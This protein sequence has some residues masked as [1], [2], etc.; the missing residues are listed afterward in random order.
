MDIFWAFLSQ[1]GCVFFFFSPNEPFYDY[2]VTNDSARQEPL[3]INAS[4]PNELVYFFRFNNV[5]LQRLA[6][7]IASQL[8]TFGNLY[9]TTKVNEADYILLPEEVCYGDD[10]DALEKLLDQAKQGVKIGVLQAHRDAKIE[11]IAKKNG[12]PPPVFVTRKPFGP[13]SFS[14]LI[15]L[16]NKEESSTHDF[17]SSG[18]LSQEDNLGARQLYQNDDEIGNKKNTK[19]SDKE[20]NHTIDLIF[21]TNTSDEILRGTPPAARLLRPL[22]NSSPTEK[23]QKEVPP[24]FSALCVEDNA[25]NMRILTRVLSQCDIPFC[26]AVDGQEAVEQFKEQQPTLIL[27]DINMPKMN[28]YDACKEMRRIEEQKKRASY[29]IAITALS[30]DFSKNRGIEECGMDEWLSK[31]LDILK[32]KEKIKCLYQAYQQEQ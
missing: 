21:S 31:P 6:G 5:G 9:T 26:M 28:G 1:S 32:F 14:R 24:T 4:S 20:D 3:A 2:R 25:L 18:R 17:G 16:A 15:Q 13:R 23:R 12:S 11:L 8:A 27:L 19:K 22:S 29:I 30:D 7:S 10:N